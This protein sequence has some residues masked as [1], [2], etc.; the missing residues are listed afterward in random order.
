[1]SGIIDNIMIL[2]KMRA[3]DL[4]VLLT[5]T[6]KALEECGNERTTNEQTEKVENFVKE[7]TTNVNNLLTRFYFLKEHKDM[8]EEQTRTLVDFVNFVKSVTEKVQS[9]LACFQKADSQRFEENLDEEI[10]EM[11]TCIKRRLKEY[12]EALSGANHTLKRRLSK[13]FSNALESIHKFF[14]GKRAALK[15][16]EEAEQDGPQTYGFEDAP[17]ESVEPH[18][19]R[20]ECFVDALDR[21]TGGSSSEKSER[22]IHLEV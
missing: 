11:G 21:N 7:L 20:S 22:Q 15:E 8:T 6:Q 2:Y 13:C 1:M 9:L 12:D 19:T 18:D 3:D 14:R 10:K 16:T 4:G 17:L 5:N